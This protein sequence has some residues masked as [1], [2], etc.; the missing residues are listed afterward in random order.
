MADAPRPRPTLKERLSAH[1]AEYGQIAV[2]TYLVISLA[3]IAAFSIAIGAGVRPSTSSGVLGVIGAGW[4]AA[5]TTVPLR[6][7]ATLAVTPA[8][9]AVVRRRS[10]RA[11]AGEASADAPGRPAAPAPAPV[12]APGD[13]PAA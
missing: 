11:G 1:L 8:V 9:A 10:S 2:V 4:L 13:P 5:K 12:A 6:I 3:A 7:L